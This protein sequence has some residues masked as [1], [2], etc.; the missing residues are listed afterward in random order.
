M[1]IQLTS[2][3]TTLMTNRGLASPRLPL[4]TLHWLNDFN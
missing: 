4:L 3:W 1:L 2:S